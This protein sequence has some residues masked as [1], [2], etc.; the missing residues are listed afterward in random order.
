MVDITIPAIVA[1]GFEISLLRADI[2]L[3]KMDSS[4]VVVS[5][6]GAR[7][8]ASFPLTPQKEADARAW[9][10]ALSRLSSLAN[11]FRFTPPD[12]TGPRSGYS[13]ANPLVAGA[14]QLGLSLS[15]DGVT[16]ST[17]IVRAGDYLEVNGEFKI[18]TTDATSTGLG[19][20]TISFEPALR[21]APA[22]NAVIQ[23]Q[24]PKA[25][26]RLTN[27]RASQSVRPGKIYDHS[28]DAIEAF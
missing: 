21:Q 1:A 27:P 11:T 24:T 2:E 19:A 28:I 25:T 17:L 7:W 9:F 13:G 8:A 16:A 15:A 10:A 12:F 26:M 23:L 6:F 20:V 3:G 22:D 5:P 18:V 4:Q 14:G